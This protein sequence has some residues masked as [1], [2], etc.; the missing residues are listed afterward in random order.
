MK[1]DEKTIFDGMSMTDAIG[2]YKDYQSRFN[3]IKNEIYEKAKKAIVD[4]VHYFCTEPFDG[5]YSAYFP[6]ALTMNDEDNED[7]T[8][9]YECVY[10]DKIGRVQMVEWTWNEEKMMDDEY[11]HGIYKN[12]E[13]VDLYKKLDRM[14]FF[15]EKYEND[16]IQA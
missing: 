15:D 8:R 2:K 1:E 14:G 3:D 11:T 12:D 6:F 16:F 13:M 5:E 9:R 10:I 4:R 7:R